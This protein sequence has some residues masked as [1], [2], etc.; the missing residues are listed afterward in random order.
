MGK[1]TCDRLR[2]GR[3]GFLNVLPIYHPLEAGFISHPF[4]LVCGVP[5]TLNG[6]MASGD[7]DLGVVS[8][9]E[10]ARHSRRYFILPDLSISCRGEVQSVLLLSREPVERLG[11]KTIL[12]TAQ[13]HTSVGLLRILLSLR[14]GVDAVFQPGNCTEALERGDPPAAFLAIGDEALRLRHHPL[15]PHRMDL[16]ADW[17]AWTGLPFVFAVWVIQRSAVER[18]N[19]HLG[20]AL[21]TLASAKKWGRENM[22]HVCAQA[23]TKGVLNVGELREY[24]TC[25]RYE[26]GPDERKGLELFF[27]YLAQ[28]GVTDE[29]PGLDIFAPMAPAIPRTEMRAET[30]MV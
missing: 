11:G 12:V 22:E 8:S 9:I 27:R 16:G 17:H 18:W 15:Y 26:L 10:Y 20:E 4:E 28:I 2:L 14:Y 5:A 23:A 1:S 19:G 29:A 30:A 25:L 3:I 21:A 6:L 7:L 24:Y 13:S